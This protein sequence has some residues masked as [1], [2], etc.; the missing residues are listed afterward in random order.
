MKPGSG[1]RPE[2]L[3]FARAMNAK[4]E[5]HNHDRGEYGW[6]TAPPARL[7]DWLRDYYYGLLGALD[8]GAPPD[9][10]L[11]KAANVANLAMMIADVC[12]GLTHGK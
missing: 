12:G 6:R 5:G 10:V 11:S 1:L 9:E 4:I 2:V 8:R 7:A 3:A